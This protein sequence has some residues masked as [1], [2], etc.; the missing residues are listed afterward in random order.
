M[1]VQV[2]RDRIASVAQLEGVLR[3]RQRGWLVVVRRGNRLLQLQ[4]A[5]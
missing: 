1:I 3:Q 4:V 2:G 5:G